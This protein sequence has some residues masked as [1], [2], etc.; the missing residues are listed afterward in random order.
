MANTI[1]FKRLPDN[2]PFDALSVS[3][4]L[5]VDSWLWSF[6]MEIPSR[7]FLDLIKPQGG[8]LIDV[9]IAVNG[10]KWIC[11]VEG[12]HESAAFGRRSWTVTGRSPSAEL[13]DPYCTRQ[14]YV[15]TVATQGSQFV[16]DILQYSG[17]SHSWAASDYLDPLTGWL[18]PAGA[19]TYQDQTKIGAIQQLAAAV[20]AI[21]QTPPD[22][23]TTPTLTI[24]PRFPVSPWQW[25]GVTPEVGIIDA[26]FEEVGR[27]WMPAPLY[28]AVVVAGVNYGKIVSVKRTG[29][30]GD[31]QAPTFTSDLI[32]TD[33]AGR[34]SGR[35]IMGRS[36]NWIKHTI[37]LFS[38]YPDGTPPGLLVPGTMIAVQEG[39][40]TWNGQ[41]TGTTIAASNV[42]REVRQTIEVEEYAD[43]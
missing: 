5:D 10:W 20:G 12:W 1:L 3:M 30:A 35:I 19:F 9:E 39:A 13:G 33:G 29:T 17:W 32:C 40:T 2:V 7:A 6:Q 22:T 26:Q 8:T 24:K 4:Q 36:G 38:L 27:N 18:I 42:S 14:S 16:T 34:E 11:R 43:V 15:S 28:N 41:V 25:V 37:R 21:I 31:K 23:V